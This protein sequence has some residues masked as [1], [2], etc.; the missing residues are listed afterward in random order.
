MDALSWDEQCD[1]LVLG[2]GPAARAIASLLSA[3]R[4]GDNSNKDDPVSVIMADQNLDRLFPPNYGAWHDE[5]DSLVA[6]YSAAG[7]RFEGGNCGSAVDRK[8]DIT[9]C[10]FGGS[11]DQPMTDRTRLDRPYY[12]VDKDALRESLTPSLSSTSSNSA[13]RMVRANHISTALAPNVFTPSGSLQHDAQGS[14]VQLRQ[15]DGNVVTVRAQLVVDCT[16]HETKLVL[17]E[18]GRETN[19]SPGFQIAYGCLVDIECANDGSDSSRIGPYA[20]D[21]MTLFDYRTDHYDSTDEATQQKVAQSPTFMYTMPLQGNRVFFEETSLVA[22]PG[23]SFQEC[24]DRTMQR[25]EHHGIRITKLVEEEFCY[26]PMGGAL[27][28]KDQRIIA[29]GGAAVM[30]HP[31][32]GYHLCRCL[33]AALDLSSVLRRELNAASVAMTASNGDSCVNLDRISAQCYHTLWSPSNIGQRNFAVFG[34]E[35]LM[36]QNV[37]GLRGFFDGFFRLPL[38]LWAGF[39]AGWPGLPH[40]ECHETWNARLWF[41]LNFLVRLPSS[42]ALDMTASIVT[43]IVTTNLSLAQSVTPFLGSPSSYEYQPN[44]DVVGDVAAKM[45]ARRMIQES[46]VVEDVP[47]DFENSVSIRSKGDVLPLTQRSQ[48]RMDTW[49]QVRSEELPVTNAQL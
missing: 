47:V 31:A 15:T 16:G 40:N 38:P 8:W 12:R 44:K 25:L 9:D 29:L 6:R 46:K 19:T 23:L 1:V 5:W 30:V 3:P 11:F 26:I 22:R 37:Q 45:E 13:Y 49:S 33:A 43:Y 42:V 32:T 41:G 7:V 48:T 2:S 10:F 27:P 17:R 4:S 20:K 14:T 24:K 34:G 35:Y 21:A 36:R 18:S 39:L 28:A